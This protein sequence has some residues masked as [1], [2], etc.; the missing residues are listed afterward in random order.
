MADPE[1]ENNAPEPEEEGEIVTVAMSP[2]AW[3][4]VTILIGVA[5]ATL[6]VLMY[7]LAGNLQ[8]II[9]RRVS[10][11]TYLP[12][13]TGIDRKDKVEIDGIPVGKVTS[14]TLTGS[15]EPSRI[16]RVEMSIRKNYLS[17]IPVDSR[18]EVTA[19]NL[20]GDKYINIRKGV[21]HEYLKPGDELLLQPPDSNFDAADL[22][23]SMQSVINRMNQLL[24]QIDNPKTN[25]GQT[26]QGE[27]YY[28]HF[29]N[30]IKG[31]Q[32]AVHSY[33]SPK[34]AVGKALFG[35]ELYDQLRS[36]I[37]EIDAQLATIQRGEGRLGHIY[38]S[39]EDY[40]QLQKQIAGYHQ[41][42]ADFRKSQYLANDD[43]Y[44]SVKLI[45]EHLNGVVDALAA[46]P[47]AESAQL[48]ESLNGELRELE[49]SLSDFR[50]NPQ[51]YLRLK[52]R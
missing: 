36:P 47:M 16:V 15:N 22:I 42:I 45:L 32:A 21:G 37:L 33:G 5:I 51:K 48:Y 20:L 30:S 2:V 39:A 44:R 7:L 31:F 52:V 9:Q 3:I 12:D 24:D 1:P 41:A 40:D 28:N 14:V 27:D 8:D 43:E 34:N 49:K 19:D 13:A 38:A 10:I 23:V 4:R 35:T 29:V 11:V 17:S 50:Q 26:I 18:A 46:S 6:S 25:I